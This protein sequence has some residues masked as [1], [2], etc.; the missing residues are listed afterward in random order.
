MTKLNDGEALA[1][2]GAMTRD[3]AEVLASFIASEGYE[4]PPQRPMIY[5]AMIKAMR[6]IGAVTKSQEYSGGGARYNFRGIDA[7]VNAT[8]P[9]LRDAGVFILPEVLESRRADTWTGANKTQSKETFIR[10]RYTFMAEDGSSVAATVEGESLDTS[11]KGLAK[12]ASVAMRILLL[13]TFQIPTDDPDPD[14]QHLER[15]GTGQMTEPIKKWLRRGI[16][17]AG[18]ERLAEL[19]WMVNA[20]AAMEQ[21]ALEGESSRVTWYGLMRARLNAELEACATLNACRELH[22]KLGKALE[23]TVAPQVAMTDAIKARMEKLGAEMVQRENA[24][25]SRIASSENREGVDTIAAELDAAL[26]S[27]LLTPDKHAN[28][29]GFAQERWK[30]LLEREVAEPVADMADV[31]G[32]PG[33]PEDFDG[34]IG[35]G[36]DDHLTE[37]DAQAWGQH[38]GK[39]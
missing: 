20:H 24:Y 5:A 17:Q 9:A 21:T 29:R 7:V 38:G 33:P 11:D 3:N 10:I 26:E 25:A 22:G 8:G 30:K 19:W 1:M 37:A 36:P 4:M 16:E 27:G 39:G 28:L 13:Q 6:A 15:A 31:A 12:A 14:S 2:L 32:E 23:I 18:V 35:D 34:P